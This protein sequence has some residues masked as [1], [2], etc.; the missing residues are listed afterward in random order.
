MV[1]ELGLFGDVRTA[2]VYAFGA[3]RQI[4]RFQA[5]SF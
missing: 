4:F 2:R 1:L 3:S 5:L